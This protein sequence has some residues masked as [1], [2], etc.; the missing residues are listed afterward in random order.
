MVD[1]TSTIFLGCSEE[2]NRAWMR[3]LLGLNPHDF[4][5]NLF[6]LRLTAIKLHETAG[7]AETVFRFP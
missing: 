5:S 6:R 7:D 1:L 3:R 2:R 4:R